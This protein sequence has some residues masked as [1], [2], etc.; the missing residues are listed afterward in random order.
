MD[1]R[2]QDDLGKGR[3][4]VTSERDMSERDRQRAADTGRANPATGDGR[5][6]NPNDAGRGL[7]MTEHQREHLKVL[8]DEAAV[9]LE[10]NLTYDEAERKIE[11]L[12]VRAGRKP[13]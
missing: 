8:S 2:N 9:P 12:Q 5:G 3:G 6:I 7:P 1:D 11:E 13:G 10:D 4:E